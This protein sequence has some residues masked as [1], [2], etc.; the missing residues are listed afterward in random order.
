VKATTTVSLDGASIAA[1]ISTPI[2]RMIHSAI[3]SIGGGGTNGDSGFD[4]R[5][6]VAYPDTFHGGGH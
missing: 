1:A 6:H 4:G 5:E 3:A 2:E